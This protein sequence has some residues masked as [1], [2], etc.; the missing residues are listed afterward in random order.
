[1]GYLGSAARNV[2]WCGVHYWLPHTYWATVYLGSASRI[3]LLCEVHY[4]YL[5]LAG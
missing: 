1:M 4:W 5:M 3:G 2:L